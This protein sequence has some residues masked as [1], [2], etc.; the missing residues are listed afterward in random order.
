MT[1]DRRA[2]ALVATSVVAIALGA[3]SG[4][5]G[6]GG[7]DEVVDIAIN[8][9]V[10]YEANAGVVGHL[11]EEEMGFTVEYKE[12][13][14]QV[15][16]EGFESGEVDAI[17]E[18][19]GHADLIQT[20]V[21]DKA[22]AVAA[23]S[24]GIDGIIGWFVPPWMA[25]EYPD[26]TDWENLN[27]YAEMFK[28]SE[29][30]DKGQF[31]A[32]DPSFVTSDAGIIAG[33]ELDYEVVYAGSEAALIEAF[34]KAEENKTPLL[35]YFYSPQ[36]FFDE[37]PLVKIDLPPYTEGCDADPN[38]ITC[39]Y[40]P[41]S[42]LDKYISKNLEEK[43]PRA[44]EFIKNFEWTAEHQNAVANA[45]TNGDKT[46]EEAAAEWVAANEAVWQPWIPAE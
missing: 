30:G 9:W 28:T 32:G 19:W 5:G 22:V 17:L 38:L 27:G 7:T 46:R 25:T 10:G 35:G 2:R 3:C 15:S 31:L 13:A 29:S 43:A 40:A 21:T 8:P 36:W 37:V 16:W 11:L 14:E 42:P 18:N 6:G 34:R 44:A 41:Y 1:I 33:L 24:T 39:D 23:G 20:Y 45:I 26:I 12:L 4:G